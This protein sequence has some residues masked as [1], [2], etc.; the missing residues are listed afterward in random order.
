MQTSFHLAHVQIPRTENSLLFQT[1]RGAVDII[2]RDLAVAVQ[3]FGQSGGLLSEAEVETLKKRG[4]LTESTPR[5][6]LEQAQAVMRLSA[7]NYRRLVEL[8]LR[9]RKAPHSR[10]TSRRSFRSRRQ[11]PATRDWW[12]L[13][14]KYSSPR[15]IPT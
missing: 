9:R 8:A 10:P 12:R 13:A 6:E 1:F 15:L 7:K 14:S 2:P 3:D 11:S 4:Y 5:Q